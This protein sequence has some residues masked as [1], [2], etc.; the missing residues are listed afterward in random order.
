MPL[1]IIGGMVNGVMN[2]ANTA[3]QNDYNKKAAEQAFE[4]DKELL[5]L[6]QGFNAEEAEKAR[7]FQRA[8]YEDY[9]T[10]EAQMSQ[11]KSAGLSPALI[12]AKGMGSVGQSAPT[13]SAGAS[14]SATRGVPLGVGLH[15]SGIESI[16]GE[17]LDLEAIKNKIAERQRIKQQT[18]MW[19][20]EEEQI[21]AVTKATN[22]D[23]SLKN[24]NAGKLF[25]ISGSELQ[26][27]NDGAQWN[28]AWS[29][30]SGMSYGYTVG[31]SRSHSE[32]YENAGN[33]SVGVNVLKS[34]ANIAAGGKHAE[35]VSDAI[36]GNVGEN[37][38]INAS[39]SEATGGGKS[40][41]ETW[42]KSQL[43]NV[44]VYPSD[45]ENEVNMIVVGE[46]G[47]YEDISIDLK[48]IQDL[49]K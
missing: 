4:Y 13:A 45:K 6:T 48:S 27:F 8:F 46:A 30:A 31:G 26:A 22:K 2:L 11:L 24:W 34:G 28:K 44:Y 18:A 33:A 41:G 38:G 23:I 42:S 20:A 9:M 25:T 12:Y 39:A 19:K 43:Y 49:G 21:K 3:M 1:G 14:S 37:A 40:H 47:R 29:R 10:P 5:G 15:H 36:S 16:F 32:G 7:Q 17:A 35:N